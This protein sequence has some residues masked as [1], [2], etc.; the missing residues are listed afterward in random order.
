MTWLDKLRSHQVVQSIFLHV[1]GDAT[2]N[3]N[4]FELLGK[5]TLD[6]EGSIQD[7]FHRQQPIT[8][9]MIIVIIVARIR[10]RLA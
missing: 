6:V 10:R 4:M 7:L 2:V 5:L 9:E 1:G 3:D 8:R